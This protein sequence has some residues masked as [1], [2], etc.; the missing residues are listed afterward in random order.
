M[1]ERAA[2]RGSD[3]SAAA[4]ALDALELSAGATLLITGA[5]SAVGRAAVSLAVRNGLEVFVVAG[6]HDHDLLAAL[7]ATRFVSSAGDPAATLRG[8]R[9]SGVDA[10][11]DAAGMRCAILP[12]VRSGGRIA[13]PHGWRPRLER[14]IRAVS[15]HVA[16]S[17][18]RPGGTPLARDS[19]PAPDAT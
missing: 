4:V 7:G 3:A 12:A 17:E 9:P 13:G 14:G 2:T 16:P 15:G 11:L 19:R 5:A 10:V 18:G 8:V 6:A 1:S